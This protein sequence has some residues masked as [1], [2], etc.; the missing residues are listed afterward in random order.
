[1][2]PCSLLGDRN[3]SDLKAKAP[4]PSKNWQ[5]GT[6][7]HGVMTQVTLVLKLINHVTR[8][9]I[10]TV[11]LPLSGKIHKGQQFLNS[12]FGL[13]PLDPMGNYLKGVVIAGNSMITYLNVI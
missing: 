12:N 1:M 3:A 8:K 10:F 7:L 5:T 11:M 4:V 6:S 9:D 2:T 13:F